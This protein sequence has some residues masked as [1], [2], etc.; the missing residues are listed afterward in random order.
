[1][2][3]Q[4]YANFQALL[5]A[6]LE[7]S[8]YPQCIISRTYQLLAA[9][10]K[11]RERYRLHDSLAGRTCHQAS[12]GSAVPCSENGEACPL[13]R[14]VAARAPTSVTHIHQEVQGRRK[15]QI[16]MEPLFDERGRT[17]AFIETIRPQIDHDQRG[18]ILFDIKGFMSQ[19]L[20]NA[21]VD[22]AVIDE[23]Q[24][25][26]LAVLHDELI[27]ERQSRMANG[28]DIPLVEHFICTGDGYF[29]I[30]R[31]ELDVV[32]D[33]AHCLQDL[34]AARSI[35]AYL[36]AHGGRVHSFVDLTGKM[37]VTG[38]ALGE[39]ARIHSIS[40]VKGLICSEALFEQ[41]KDN[42][43]YSISDS[44]VYEG[45]AKDGVAYHWRAVNPSV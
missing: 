12:H 13:L 28:C 18:I 3:L 25:Q 43:Y 10:K 22:T 1:M 42:P 35:E 6:T 15:V 23:R 16:D 7:A 9:N 26:M 30:C 33:I 14:C 41:W 38:Y 39:A 11:Y 24:E 4:P 40:K 20:S 21:K 44:T 36:V 37:N 29:M 19:G 31:P 17:F 8:P 27:A 45:T 2:S 5:Q 34:L 32:L